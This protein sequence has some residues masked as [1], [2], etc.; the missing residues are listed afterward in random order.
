M[1]IKQP[2][3]I[4]GI[5]DV[6]VAK[7]SAF[8]AAAMFFFTFLFSILYMIREGRRLVLEEGDRR[9]G[10]AGMG[11]LGGDYQQVAM[12][13]FDPDNTQVPETF[14]RGTLA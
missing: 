6:E 12:S 14:E 5:E 13:D 1:L 11:R 3:F 10:S 2:F 4:G 9:P 7:G 8:G